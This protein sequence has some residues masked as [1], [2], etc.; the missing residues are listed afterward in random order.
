MAT[1]EKGWWVTIKTTD[2]TVS[3]VIVPATPGKIPMQAEIKEIDVLASEKKADVDEKDEKPKVVGV[4]NYST[5]KTLTTTLATH[6][7]HSR[8]ADLP[9]STTC[10]DCNILHCHYRRHGFNSP[11]TPVYTNGS[12]GMA[13]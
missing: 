13:R 10:T 4:P 11:G 6:P 5:T 9:H 2:G 12:R 8:R 3:E 1:V 7:G